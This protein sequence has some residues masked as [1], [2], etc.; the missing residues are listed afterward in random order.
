MTVPTSAPVERKVTA[1]TLVAFLASIGIAVLNSLSGSDLLGALPPV[2][3]ALI[4]AVVPT[5]VVFLGGYA[6]PHTPR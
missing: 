3:Q 5:L 6:A 1:S 4:L 2:A